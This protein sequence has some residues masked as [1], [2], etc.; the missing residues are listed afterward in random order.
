[1]F[2]NRVLRSIFGPKRDEIAERWRKLHNDELYNLYSLLRI[3]RMVNSR[4][5]RWTGH[6]AQMGMKRNTYRLLMGKPQGK[7]PL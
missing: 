2:E 6:A 1:V 3:I 7:N 5:M 4:T